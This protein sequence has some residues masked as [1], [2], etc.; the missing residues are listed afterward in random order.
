MKKLNIT[1]TILLTVIICYGQ[2]E[3]LTYTEV[4][5][6]N[7]ASKDLLYNRARMWV[8]DNFKNTNNGVKIEDREAG[9]I[10]SKGFFRYKPT[11]FNGGGAMEGII[12]Y[13]LKIF[14][15]TNLTHLVHFLFVL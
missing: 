3:K 8:I 11:F 2:G 1:L 7:G 6:V 13:K 4:I 12:N 10:V 14:I 15:K 9:E 5:Y